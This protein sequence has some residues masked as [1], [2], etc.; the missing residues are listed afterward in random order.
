MIY[1]HKPLPAGGLNLHPRQENKPEIL[2][3]T[4]ESASAAS[5]SVWEYSLGNRCSLGLTLH[6]WN[7]PLVHPLTLTVP[8]PRAT[9]EKGYHSVFGKQ[10]R[11]QGVKKREKKQI[12]NYR[13]D[14]FGLGSGR[15]RERDGDSPPIFQRPVCYVGSHWGEQFMADG[16]GSSSI[17]QKATSGSI[18]TVLA[19]HIN[20]R[21]YVVLSVQ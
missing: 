1:T 6:L 21:L 17:P 7:H 15:D 13:V 9:G 2:Q 20:S 14:H 3:Q 11:I 18:A 4:S 5:R 8:D 10:R 16:S 19:G 12:M